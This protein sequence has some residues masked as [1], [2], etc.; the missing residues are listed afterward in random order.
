MRISPALLVVV[1]LTIGATGLTLASALLV[2]IGVAIIIASGLTRMLA[3]R[4]QG[5]A[6]GGA[7]GLPLADG[8]RRETPARRSFFSRASY[9]L[10]PRARDNRKPAAAPDQPGSPA[11][12]AVMSP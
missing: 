11:A 8:T 9:G 1:G 4:V 10:C 6:D 2:V 3:A 12:T 5:R 7:P